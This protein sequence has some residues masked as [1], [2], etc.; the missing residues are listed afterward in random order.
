M[1]KIINNIKLK[2]ILILVAMV[3]I[4]LVVYGFITINNQA[5][6]ITSYSYDEKDEMAESIRDQAENIIIS[7]ED[8][9]HLAAEARS[10]KNLDINQMESYL[11]TMV[12]KSEYI[13]NAF[14]INQKGKEIYKTS[15]ESKNHFEQQYFERALAGKNAFSEVMISDLFES[16]IVIHT[17]PIRKDGEVIGVLGASLDLAYLSKL[18]EDNSPGKTGYGFVVNKNG[19]VIAHP[20]Q[21]KVMDLHDYSDLKPVK[22]VIEGKD[23]NLVFNYNGTETLAS[24][25][26]IEETG[27]GV[28]IQLSSQEA[29]SEVDAAMWR[30]VMLIG[31]TLLIGIIIAYFVGNYISNPIVAASKQA[32]EVADGNL[33]E[34]IDDKYLKRKDELGVLA[35]S[36]NKMTKSLNDIL[37]DVSDI[38]TNLSSSSQEL[39]ASSE[40]ITASAEEVGS[41]IEEVASGAEEQTAQI[42]ETS[43]NVEQLDDNMENIEN[44]SRNIDEQADDVL[45]NIK[46]G[47]KILEKSTQQVKEVKG[48]SEAVSKKINKLGTLSNEIGNIVELISDISEQTNLL[49]LNAAIEAARAGEAGR[50]FSVVAD[51]IRELAE[52]TSEATEK[53]NNLI[54]NIQVGVKETINQMEKSEK[55]VDEGVDKIK[56]ADS[57]IERIHETANNLKDYIEDILLTAKKVNERSEKVSASIDEIAVASEQASSNAEEVAASSEEQSASTEEIAGAAENLAKMAERLNNKINEFDV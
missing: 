26:P 56:S 17:T 20:D 19:Q 51:E 3:G 14:V 13:E 22:Q 2:I 27:W 24:Y 48:Q 32:K 4:P 39:S 16:P 50:G 11:D 31:V 8:I 7:S 43:S 9:I 34:R 52:E 42:E 36:I 29:L 38:A 46:K 6:L 23:G 33:T 40:E 5:D 37:E 45:K 41:A 53:I 15:G 28:V 44:M 1:L 57:S 49:A 10:L 30:A 21:E 55:A 12:K 18:A 25:V 47:N 54:N 35:K